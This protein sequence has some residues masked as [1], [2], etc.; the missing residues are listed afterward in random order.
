MHALL[1]WVDMTAL[2]DE[3]LDPQAELRAQR[4]E[5]RASEVGIV[6]YL[7]VGDR[8][9]IGYTADLTRRRTEYPPTA[10]LLATEI[11][12]RALERRR[13]ED[14]RVYLAGG[15]EWFYPAPELIS[16]VQSI[17]A[18]SPPESSRDHL[19]R[20]LVA[21]QTVETARRVG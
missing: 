21:R 4:R 5:Q 17:P 18:P 15:R 16:F 12:T 20:S 14:F 2:V 7:C 3:G 13:H 1:V 19:R 9:K 6:Y 10:E 11:G 8:I